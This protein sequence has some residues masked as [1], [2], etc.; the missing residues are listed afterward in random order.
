MTCPPERPVKKRQPYRRT[1]FFF[2][3][4]GPTGSKP[5]R[6]RLIVAGEPTSSGGTWGLGHP[7]RR[8][9]NGS[10]YGPHSKCSP[11]LFLVLV[12]VL[13]VRAKC[14]KLIQRPADLLQS[15][16]SHFNVCLK[17]PN[18]WPCPACQTLLQSLLINPR[19]ARA[20]RPMLL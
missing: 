8:Q 11:S 20:A 5:R 9:C 15:L 10:R 7:I 6:Q 4:A 1:T 18:H 3:V 12:I 2:E 13:H 16:A 17:P 19:P 14:T